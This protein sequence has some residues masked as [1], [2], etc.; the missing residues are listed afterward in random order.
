[1]PPISECIRDSDGIQQSNVS[2]K[3]KKLSTLRG[4]SQLADLRGALC[5]PTSNLTLDAD[6]VGAEAAFDVL[7]NPAAPTTDYTGLNEG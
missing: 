7:H 2:T 3:E 4:H 6:L 5:V 1:M